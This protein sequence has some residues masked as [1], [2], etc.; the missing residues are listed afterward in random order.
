M[1]RRY[2]PLKT[3][4]VHVEKRVGSD[5]PLIT[6]FAAMYFDPEDP[7]TEYELW[8]DMYEQM[9]PGCFDRALR[10]NQDVRGL[11]NHDP[12]M[13]LGRTSAGTMRLNLT[14]KGL[15]YEINPPDTQAGRDCVTSIERGDLT[16]SSFTFSASDVTWREQNGKIIR[17]I[18]DVQLYDCGPVT[19]PAY[20]AT[21]TG[22]RAAAG[23]V[24]DLR[25]AYD[26]WKA[27]QRIQGR[28]GRL[29]AV[30]ARLVAL[31]LDEKR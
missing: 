25:R 9:M 24:E 6:G 14:A 18:R 8:E 4:Q 20:E 31:D 11:M 13:L 22:L 15:A 16:G 12:N 3:A 27:K 17:E 5:T 21:T 23:E 19:F 7:G 2:L 30:R 26:G 1:E 29:A 28:E 10:E